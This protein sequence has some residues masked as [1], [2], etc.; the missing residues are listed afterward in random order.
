MHLCSGLALCAGMAAS[1]VCA[2]IPPF[3][4]GSAACGGCAS[5]ALPSRCRVVQ[6]DSF[7][8]SPRDT[9]GQKT[10]H[11]SLLETATELVPLRP[12][13]RSTNHSDIHVR[14]HP[15]S[16]EFSESVV[17]PMQTAPPF[18]STLCVHAPMYP[19]YVSTIA[20]FQWSM[21]H[22]W[23]VAWYTLL[24]NHMGIAEHCCTTE[25]RQ[26]NPAC[27]KNEKLSSSILL[28]MSITIKIQASLRLI[29]SS[30]P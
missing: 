12:G 20:G 19:A 11:S 10:W 14:L 24:S 27:K 7:C 29:H 9:Q 22:N 3:P 2:C 8:R 16:F 23:P 18:V 30:L 5:S 4:M 17:L 21:Q 6:N 28:T 26:A 1:D 13:A 15:L 25:G